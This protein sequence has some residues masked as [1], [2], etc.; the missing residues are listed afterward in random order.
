M[1]SWSPGSSPASADHT[2]SRSWAWSSAAPRSAVRLTGAVLVAGADACGPC[3]RR[4]HSFRATAYSQGRSRAR[5]T[6]QRQ[7]HLGHHEGV[8]DRPGRL[9]RLAQQR[10]AISVQRRSELIVGGRQGGRIARHDRRHQFPVTHAINAMASREVSDESGRIAEN[11]R[12][13]FRY[14]RPALRAAPP[15]RPVW[16]RAAA[17]HAAD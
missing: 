16:R 17:N 4:W 13:A 8:V 14:R 3:S 12:P 6:Q 11:Q 7:L 10:P 1:I 2:S 15:G 5:V 9:G